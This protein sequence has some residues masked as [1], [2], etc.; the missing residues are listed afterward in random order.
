MR[1]IQLLTTLIIPIFAIEARSDKTA[2]KAGNLSFRRVIGDKRD[3][4]IIRTDA[5]AHNLGM[6]IKGMTLSEQARRAQL[7]R[8][9]MRSQVLPVVQ[10]I[11]TAMPQ[12]ELP[13]FKSTV[14]KKGYDLT[15]KLYN[16]NIQLSKRQL[17]E[18]LAHFYEIQVEDNKRA[19]VDFKQTLDIELKQSYQ[20]NTEHLRKVFATHQDQ[21]KAQLKGLFPKLFQ[22]ADIPIE[23]LDGK[24][25]EK[26][27]D[28][29]GI[30]DDEDDYEDDYEEDEDEEDELE[31]VAK[32][33]V[34]PRS[35]QPTPAATDKR[36]RV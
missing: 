26:Q 17:E 32:N 23:T 36:K 1:Y 30:Y 3:R 27:V 16:E 5:A 29:V 7:R 10:S 12:L 11:D 9:G 24:R 33:P 20:K 2:R 4:A 35:K 31:P 15:V 6:K 8:E 18:Q 28:E 14:G 34:N 22:N 21:L 13:K 19:L 25:K